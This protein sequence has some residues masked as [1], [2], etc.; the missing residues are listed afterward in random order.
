MK[1]WIAGLAL[2]ALATPVRAD[3]KP[4][5][6]N[7]AAV[8][9]NDLDKKLTAALAARFT[10]VD[11]AEGDVYAAPKVLA[12]SLPSAARS[13]TG[14]ALHGYVLVAYVVSVDGLASDPII[15]ESTDPRLDRF[16]LE[17][18]RAWRFTPGSVNGKVVPTASGQEFDFLSDV[19]RPRSS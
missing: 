7:H 5:I 18:M 1:I 19:S 16:A 3:D 17:A 6:Y 2:L 11:V 10:V 14:E 12:G 8:P 15:V 4:T 13:E 9:A